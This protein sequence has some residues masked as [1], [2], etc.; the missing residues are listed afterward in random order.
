MVDLACFLQI[1]NKNAQCLFWLLKGEL[2]PKLKLSMF[3]VLSQ[4]Y[5]HFCEK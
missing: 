2:H 1:Q 3:C 5:Q 4:N